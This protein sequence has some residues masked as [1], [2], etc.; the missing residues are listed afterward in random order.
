LEVE[1]GKQ[2]NRPLASFLCG[3]A[4]VPGVASWKMQNTQLSTCNTWHLTVRYRRVVVVS[5]PF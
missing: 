1:R 3:W 4:L 2:K 5:L